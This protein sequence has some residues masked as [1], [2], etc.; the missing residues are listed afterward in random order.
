MPHTPLRELKPEIFTD[1]VDNPYN[2]D[3]LDSDDEV[4]LVNDRYEFDYIK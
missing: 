4:P 3:D 1:E 2:F